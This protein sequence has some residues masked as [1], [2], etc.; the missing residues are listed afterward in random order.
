VR[1]FAPEV[2]VEGD[3]TDEGADLRCRFWDREV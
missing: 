2:T 3:G 1:A